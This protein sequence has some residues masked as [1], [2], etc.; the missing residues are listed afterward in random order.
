MTFFRPD[1]RKEKIHKYGHMH[2][3]DILDRAD[4]FENELIILS[5]LSTRTAVDSAAIALKKRLPQSL[6]DRVYLWG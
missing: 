6:Y 5:H 2:L 1:H 4:Q 3:D